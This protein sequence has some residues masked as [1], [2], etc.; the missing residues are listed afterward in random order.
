MSKHLLV[1]ED[2]G[3]STTHPT[4]LNDTFV[5]LESAHAL[6]SLIV[7]SL[8]ASTLKS[9]D[10]PPDISV[11]HEDAN[12]ASIASHEIAGTVARQLIRVERGKGDLYE[13]DLP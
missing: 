2:G 6:Q 7:K 13:G 8:V 5:R 9:E 10:F 11:I 12:H 4:R 3:S 1:N